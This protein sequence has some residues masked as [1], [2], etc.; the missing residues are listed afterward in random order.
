MA[1]GWGSRVGGKTFLGK[2]LGPRGLGV[3]LGPTAQG[4]A[5]APDCMADRTA[6][7]EEG[8]PEWVGFFITCGWF[9]WG[10]SHLVLYSLVIVALQLILISHLL[11][12]QARLGK[13]VPVGFKPTPV[14]SYGHQG[15]DPR[16]SKN[17]AA[18]E[19]QGRWRTMQSKTW[20]MMIGDGLNSLRLNSRLSTANKMT[21]A[22]VLWSYNSIIQ[23]QSQ[24]N[25]PFIPINKIC[26]NPWAFRTSAELWI[27][28]GDGLG[29]GL[30]LLGNGVGKNGFALL[31]CR[32]SHFLC[33]LP[34][35]KAFLFS[36]F[37]GF[38]DPLKWTR[39]QLS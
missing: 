37:C 11:F 24:P 1:F 6:T 38:W 12:F 8:A 29:D 16:M 3:A 36:F 35:D 10:L 13:T 28:L 19:G 34:T 4:Q 17:K 21:T 27:F 22:H 20:K 26:S 39:N 7:A 31:V 25:S 18:Q 33:F 23:P 14:T 15:F 32:F 30:E 5:V 2:H 9:F